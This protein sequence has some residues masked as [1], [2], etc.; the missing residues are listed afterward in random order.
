MVSKIVSKGEAGKKPFASLL[1]G[2][3]VSYLETPV[4]AA[5]NLGQSVVDP[6]GDSHPLYSIDQFGFVECPK[7]FKYRLAEIRL[8]K[9]DL[10]VEVKE[11][12]KAE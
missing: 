8:D 4:E 11:E 7:D 9:V 6:N 12:A 1:E 3:V 5:E 2:D 10:P